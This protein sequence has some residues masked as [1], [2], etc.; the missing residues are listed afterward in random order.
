MRRSASGR[1]RRLQSGPLRPRI[2][3]PVCAYSPATSASRSHRLRCDRVLLGEIAAHLQAAGD[4]LVHAVD[5]AHDALD[6]IAVGFFGEHAQ[7]EA[8]A[9]QR[10]AQV[11][12]NA[13]QQRGA[14]GKQFLDLHAHAVEFARQHGELGRAGLRQ[15]LRAAPLADALRGAGQARQRPISQRASQAE[16]ISVTTVPTKASAAWRARAARRRG[17]PESRR[18]PLRCPRRQVGPVP[19]LAVLAGGWR[20]RLTCWP[21]R[22]AERRLQQVESKAAAAGSR[23]SR[24]AAPAPGCGAGGRCAPAARAARPPAR[25]LPF[26]CG[27]DQQCGEVAS[28]VPPQRH[29][30]EAGDDGDGEQ[31]EG[32]GRQRNHQRSAAEQRA[33]IHHVLRAPPGENR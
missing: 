1:T 23:A 15:R 11:V 27:L 14:V 22:D 12:R 16:V 5:V 8:D 32:E 24:R 20:G 2:S 25:R 6:E 10:R 19:R 3:M 21:T 31:L 4:Q 30:G 28:G 7:G 18:A 26:L 33:G 13:G 29:Q 9:R 17:W